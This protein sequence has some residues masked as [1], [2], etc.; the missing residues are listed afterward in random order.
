M[1]ERQEK[2]LTWKCEGHLR[3]LRTGALAEEQRFWRTRPSTIPLLEVRQDDGRR[4]QPPR[5]LH[6]RDEPF[7]VLRAGG[8]DE[9]ESQTATAG[10][11]NQASSCRKRRSECAIGPIEG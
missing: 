6:R 11:G 5:G 10:S 8:C 1:R 4:D 3:P 7:A 9:F 2:V